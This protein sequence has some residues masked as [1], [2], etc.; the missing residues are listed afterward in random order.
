MGSQE[1]ILHLR[2]QKFVVV[3]RGD[4]QEDAL[5]AASACIAGGLTAL[6]VAYTN[7]E[8]S[9]VIQELVKLYQTNAAVLIG[10]GTV[11]D[12]ATARLAILAG[13]QYIVSP[14]FNREVA[15]MCHL[16]AIPYIPGCMT[17]TEI[18]QALEAGC[19]MVKLFPASVLGRDY[20]SAIKAPIPQVSIMV[21]GGIKLDTVG[22][23]L[24]TGVDAVGI[25]GEFNRLA[26]QG[27][28]DK[29]QEIARG[30]SNFRQ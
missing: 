20:I 25:G 22:E 30:Y 28:F 1:V 23:W 16:Y 18:T 9:Q 13:A 7:P 5:R 27:E 11:L 26:S 24:E 29:I 4:N 17:L 8:A 15:T 14:S 10:A 21:T 3:L 19:P 2:E 6:E 12:A